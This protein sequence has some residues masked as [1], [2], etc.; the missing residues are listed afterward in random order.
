VQ[1]DRDKRHLIT[2]EN[3][4]GAGIAGALIENNQIQS[5]PPSAGLLLLELVELVQNPVPQSVNSL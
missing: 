4:S 3:G 1:P 2:L 5:S